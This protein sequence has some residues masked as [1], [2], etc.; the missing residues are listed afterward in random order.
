MGLNCVRPVDPLCALIPRG[1]ELDVTAIKESR[2][3]I[4]FL[5]GGP[6]AGKSLLTFHVDDIKLDFKVIN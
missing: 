4:I 1:N 2:L 6:G 5:I 3:P